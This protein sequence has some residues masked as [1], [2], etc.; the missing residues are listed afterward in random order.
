M[1]P[2]HLVLGSMISQLQR[3]RLHLL[4]SIVHGAQDVC[5]SDTSGLCVHN[6]RAQM[7]VHLWPH[8]FKTSSVN[9][10]SQVERSLH[11]TIVRSAEKE[12]TFKVKLDAY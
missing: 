6:Q 2:C 11:D 12:L 5:I 9:V 1:A 8:H 3:Q 10:L 4:L 7:H